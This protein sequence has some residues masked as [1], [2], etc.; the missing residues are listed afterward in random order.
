MGSGLIPSRGAKDAHTSWQ[1]K[2]KHKKEKRKQCCNK[3]NKDFFKKI[4]H[5][6][7]KNFKNKTTQINKLI[8]KEI[9]FVVTRGRKW[10]E[11]IG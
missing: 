1:K 11:K 6:K 4:V 9:R 8:V 2:K 3:F 5:I 7:K 10:A